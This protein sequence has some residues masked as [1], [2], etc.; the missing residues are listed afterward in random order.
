[1]RSY[2]E[3]N[4]PPP[5]AEQR[6]S[7]MEYVGAVVGGIGLLGIVWTALRGFLGGSRG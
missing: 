1:M 5:S 3:P 6:R 4:H 7:D 2:P